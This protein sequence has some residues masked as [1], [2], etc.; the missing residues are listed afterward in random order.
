MNPRPSMSPK[1]CSVS[2]P[3]SISGC[4]RAASLAGR[5]LQVPGGVDRRAVDARLEVQVV[6]EAMARASDVADDLAL[7]DALALRGG[8]ARLVR[9][10]RLEPAAAVRDARVVP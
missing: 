10:A 8:V 7:A 5:R 1:L 9:V 4:M 2:G 3:I 6:A